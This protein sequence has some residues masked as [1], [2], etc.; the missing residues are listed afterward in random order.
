MRRPDAAV[1]STG[2]HN[3]CLVQANS[4]SPQLHSSGTLTWGSLRAV[5]YAVR[6]KGSDAVVAESPESGAEFTLR[7]GHLLKVRLAH[8]PTGSFSLVCVYLQT[9]LQGHA[10][11]S[12]Y[13]LQLMP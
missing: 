4:T 13:G 1:T 2:P 8:A 3:A 11:G 9:C 12:A 5:R 6:V 10:V 7:D